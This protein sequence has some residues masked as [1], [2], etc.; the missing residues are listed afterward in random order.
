M[1]SLG[2]GGVG[3]DVS[4]HDTHGNPGLCPAPVHPLTLLLG[5]DLLL[6]SE[7]GDPLN[8]RVAE[9]DLRGGAGVRILALL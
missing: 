9:G 4:L 8:D 5:E 1:P 7:P 2:K 3:V 6:S